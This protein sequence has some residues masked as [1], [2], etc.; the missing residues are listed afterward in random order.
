MKDF[1]LFRN[2]S[3]FYIVYNNSYFSKMSADDFTSRH[4]VKTNLNAPDQQMI[5]LFYEGGHIGE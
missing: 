2:S 4:W 3:I 1:E 5:V